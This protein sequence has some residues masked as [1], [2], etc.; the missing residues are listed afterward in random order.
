MPKTNPST[1]TLLSSPNNVFILIGSSFIPR[2]I[3][4]FGSFGS[5]LNCFS[6]G[7]SS[8]FSSFG[9]DTGIEGTTS[10]SCFISSKIFSS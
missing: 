3:T 2:P 4:L 6:L 8:F 5:R 10:N 7:A 1:T 9:A